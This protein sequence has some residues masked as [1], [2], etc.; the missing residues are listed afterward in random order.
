M[1]SAIYSPLSNAYNHQ[2]GTAPL[3]LV[4]C[5]LLF[6][7]LFYNVLV[8]KPLQ[9]KIRPNGKGVFFGPKGESVTTLLKK[10]DANGYTGVF[11]SFGINLTSGKEALVVMSEI[12]I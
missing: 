10:V 4:W 11:Q 7:F 1:I 12:D 8:P 9:T 6:G 5:I 3:F 2:Q